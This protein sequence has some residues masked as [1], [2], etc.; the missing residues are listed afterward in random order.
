M[1][2]EKGGNGQPVLLS[3]E[4][5]KAISEVLSDLASKTK[6]KT[7]IFADINGH[8]ITQR[9]QT[10]EINIS[11]MS[12]LAAGDFAA[13]AEMSKMIGEEHR[14]KYIFHEGEKTN[15]Y[16]SSVGGSFILVVIFDSNIAL[17]MIRIFTK[18]SIDALEALLSKMT[19][20]T[21]GDKKYIDVE[22]S[23]YLNKELDKAFDF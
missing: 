22:F 2:I 5:Y 23:N 12:A 20:E 3:G 7:I 15:I 6:A 14:F 13:T 21:K 17:G 8:P 11:N 9:G 19:S 4:M 1:N 10:S 16:L 18:R